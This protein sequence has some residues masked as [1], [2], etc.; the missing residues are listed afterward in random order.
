MIRHDL[1]T[2]ALRFYAS[3]TPG[4]FEPYVAICTLLWE[5]DR[6][7]WIVGMHGAM[8]RQMIRQLVQFLNTAGVALA[9]AHRHPLHRLPFGVDVDDHVEMDVPAAARR[10]GVAAS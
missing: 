6:I 7:V 4:P 10:I 3:D 8:S 1:V 5:T 9:K 2:S